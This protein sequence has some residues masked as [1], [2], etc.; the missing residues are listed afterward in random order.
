MVRPVVITSL[1]LSL[2]AAQC[3]AAQ[4]KSTPDDPG[5]SCLLISSSSRMPDGAEA[6]AA[7]TG[8]L[9]A[10]DLVLTCNHLIRL[11]TPF[12][13]VAAKQVR[14]EGDGGRKIQARVVAT[15]PEHDLAL[16]KLSKPLS[17]RSPLRFTA[18]CLK[19]RDAVRIIGNFPDAVRNARGKLISPRVMNGFAISSAK[20]RTGF[21]GG[22]VLDEDGMVQGILSQRDDANNSIFVRSDILIEML[23]DYAKRNDLTLPCMPDVPQPDRQPPP[24]T[25]VAAAVSEPAYSEI[26]VALPTRKRTSQSSKP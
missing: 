21:S 20:V 26:V 11:P 6:T 9:I 24:D 17:T 12:G 8:F 16:L 7:G 15:Q 2:S 3:S 5:H 1:L 10:E 22:P 14:V 18:F 4:C 13:T 25:T 19:Q 23:G